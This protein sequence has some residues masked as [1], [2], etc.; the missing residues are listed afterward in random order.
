MTTRPLAAL[1]LALA[2]GASAAAITGCA[3]APRSTADQIADGID[4]ERIASDLADKADRARVAGRSDEAIALYQES[5][6]YS[7]RFPDTW[8]NLG[9]LYLDRNQEGDLGRAINHFVQAGILDPTDPRPPTNAG[10]AYLRG[11]YAA[12]A[13]DFFH[14]AL[15]IQKSYLPAL[16]GSIKSADLLATAQYEDLERVKRALLA[17]TDQQWRDYFER[18]RFLIESRLRSADDRRQPGSP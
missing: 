7:A 1:S 2:L 17:E 9:L 16:R 5:L 8:N 6:D 15:A 4:R 13:M 11:G 18:Q 12:E 14:E 3:S 10:I